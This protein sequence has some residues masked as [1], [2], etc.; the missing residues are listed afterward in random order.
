MA[1]CD[2]VN[3]VLDVENRRRA[4]LVAVDLTELDRLFSED[5]VHVHTTGLVHS[6]Q[7]LLQHINQKRAFL[8]INRGPLHIRVEGD[9]A[10]MTGT[11]TN[12]MRAKDGT[13][14]FLLHGFVTQVL[15]RSADG[16]RFIS[17]QLT[18][19]REQ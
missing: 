19:L 13:G 1:L 17:F 9:I 7:E 12:R 4:A 16:W 15:R 14:E 18:P 11:M 2:D 6:K 5:L 8:A 3:L 10:V